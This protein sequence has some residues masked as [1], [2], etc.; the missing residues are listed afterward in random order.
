MTSIHFIST[1]QPDIGFM[2]SKDQIGKSLQ[3]MQEGVVNAINAVP[4]LLYNR[5]FKPFF[6]GQGVTGPNAEKIVVESADYINIV[7]GLNEQLRLDFI[8]G[9]E[10]AED[11]E[12]YREVTSAKRGIIRNT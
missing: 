9:R 5:G 1:P 7:E 11:Y 10:Q 6:E 4:R 12:Q 3:D 2:P 8:E